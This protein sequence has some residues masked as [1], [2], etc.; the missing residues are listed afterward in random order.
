VNVA[1]PTRVLSLFAGYGGL[2]LATHAAVRDARTVCYV[3]REAF[4]VAI[5]AA[6]MEA[7]DLDAAPVWGDVSTFD[8]RPWRGAVDLV[9]GGFPCQDI[10]PA[11]TGAGIDGERSGLWREY[12]RIVR[13]VRPSYVFV[14]NSAALAVRGLDRV[15]SDLAALGMDAEWDV[16]RASDVGAP[17]ERARMFILARLPDAER[18]ELRDEPERDQRQGRYVQA[19]KRGYAIT[20]DDGSQG[21]VPDAARDA[22][23]SRRAAREDLRGA[24][25]DRAKPADANNCRGE[26]GSGRFTEEAG[27]RESFNRGPV[28]PPR[29]GDSEGWRRWAGPQPAVRRGADGTTDRVDRLRALGNGVVWQQAALAFRVLAERIGDAKRR[30]TK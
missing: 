11:G 25:L 6:R 14:E 27:Q 17:H 29:I 9:V 5:L 24:A 30:A 13:E 8:G 10:S 28:W 21:D 19:A 22:Q 18:L 1:L 12:A 15:L 7:G 4:C 20:G 16:W 26:S 3:E 23:L 2:D